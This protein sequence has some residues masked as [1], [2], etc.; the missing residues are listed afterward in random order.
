VGVGTKALLEFLLDG[1][2]PV[3][4]FAQRQ[5]AIH[6][7]VHLDS[8]TVADSSGEQVVGLFYVRETLYD[9]GNLLFD[10]F[11][12]R[13]FRQ[14]AMGSSTVQRCPNRMAPPMPMAAPTDDMA[15]LR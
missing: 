7:D 14:F 8:Y 3:V 11:G 5:V 6:A 4:G 15:S 10:I 1:R 2:C 12:Q 9:A 13:T